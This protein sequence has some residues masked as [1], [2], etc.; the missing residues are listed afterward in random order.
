LASNLVTT[1]LMQPLPPL[2]VV[3]RPRL[4]KQLGT[5]LATKLILVAAPAGSGKSTLL[6]SWLQELDRPAAWLSLDASDNDLERFLLYLVSA[7]QQ[8]EPGL[9]AGLPELLQTQ[10]PVQPESIL[11]HIVNDVAR[12]NQNLLLVL[13]DYHLITDERIHEAVAFFLDHLPPGLCLV[14]ASRTDPPLALA[15]LRARRHLVEVRADQLRFSLKEAAVFLNERLH[16]ELSPQAVAGLEERTEGWIAGLQLAALSLEGRSDKERF[17]QRFAGSHRYLVD[18]L[19]DEV[20]ERQTPDVRL[21]LQRTSI[22]ERFTASLCQAVTGQADSA[23]ILKQLVDANLFLIALDDERKWY[24]Y[25]HLFAEFLGHRLVET[26][27][28]SVAK[29][30]QRARAWLEG[31]GW[32]DEAIHHALLGGDL[33]RAGRLVENIAFSLQNTSHNAQLVKYVS[34]FPLESLVG[35]PKLGIYY[36]WALVN[37][38]R[39]DLLSAALPVIERSAAHAQQPRAVAACVLALQA[40]QRLWQM[41]FTEGVRLCREAVAVLN[42]GES[43]TSTDEERWLLTAANNLISYCYLHSDLAQANR[44]YPA[45]RVLSQRLGN[46]IGA[47][48]DFARQGW[49]KHQLGQSQQALEVFHEGL[50]ALETWRTEGARVLNM[51]ELHL[52]LARLLYEW[53]RLD[54][55][56]S[57]LQRASNFN[58]RSQFPPVLALEYEIAFRLHLAH[59]RSGAAVTMLGKLETLLGEVD[60]GNRLYSQLFGTTAQQMRL[61]LASAEAG[62]SH[63][64]DEVQAWV[65]ARNLKP[66][67]TFSYPY[68]EGYFV[69]A[70]LLL[71]QNR[72]AESLPLLERLAHAAQA[73]GRTRHLIHYLIFQALANH[74]LGREAASLAALRRALAL[75]EPETYCRSFVDQGAPVRRLLEQAAQRTPTAY[76]TR[77]LAV[78]ESDEE[79]LAA[80]KPVAAQTITRDEEWLEPLSER[81]VTVLRLLSAGQSNKGI[82]KELNLSPNTVKW[83]LK[84]LYEKFGVKGRLQAVNR[85]KDLGLL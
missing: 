69:L 60:P 14:I 70:R 26:E 71:A 44:T 29:L 53:N 24:R 25:H 59:G 31:Q 38:G 11:I 18:Y 63:L 74:K 4:N 55:V 72:A 34:R 1:K 76:L 17:V 46:H 43:Q 7:L 56:E 9:G 62:F 27:A 47:A 73:S 83:Y 5:G 85:A 22:L 79:T 41:D 19:M 35:L 82:A 33:E 66:G 30:H 37:T 78:F 10:H 3:E 36:G 61:Q 12:S 57:H 32:S 75:A 39:A 21:F 52:N 51:G 40:F 68:E 58:Q 80:P 45:A 23:V 49:L 81:E 2:Q 13:D 77:L 16:L 67:D 84:R 15:R 64:L 42:R 54:E 6:A 65:E 8:V 48:N 28:E 50:R 20:L